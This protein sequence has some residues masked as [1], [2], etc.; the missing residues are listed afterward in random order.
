ME[1]STLT[2]LLA[3]G[4][5]PLTILGF[6]DLFARIGELRIRVLFAFVDGLVKGVLLD[7][8]FLKKFSKSIYYAANRVQPVSSPPV[9]ISSRDTH[10]TDDWASP[11]D[12]DHR[13]IE[14]SDAPNF[15]RATCQMILQQWTE[16]TALV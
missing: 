10:A 13:C 4:R 5:E 6:L 9:P 8:S 2:K 3:A 7:G 1:L 12:G 16:T 15:V 11:E 14:Q